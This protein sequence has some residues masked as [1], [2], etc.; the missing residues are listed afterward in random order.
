M[1]RTEYYEELKSL[2]RSIRSDFHIA[3]PRVLKSDLRRIYKHY[4]IDIDLWPRP[5]SQSSVKLKKLRGAFFY[6]GSS[7]SVMLNRDLPDEPRIFTM[8]HELKHFLKDKDLGELYCGNHNQN[9]LIEIGAEVFAA[10]LIFPDKDFRENFM[11]IS[12]KHR[13]CPAEKLVHLKQKTLT[14]LSY[15]ALVKKAVFFKF[16]KDDD[17]KDVKWRQLEDK[18]YNI[19]RYNRN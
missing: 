2:A 8:G 12:V 18:L 13:T 5:G 7:A 10:E 16:A 11:D 4:E 6:N 17:F 19:P 3:T 1:S 15:A 9:E 14:T